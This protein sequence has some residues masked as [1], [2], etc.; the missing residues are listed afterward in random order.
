MVFVDMC[1]ILYAK[2]KSWFF[3]SNG[4][5][6]FVKKWLKRRRRARSSL[7]YHRAA[8]QKASNQ[9]GSISE[10]SD[11][12]AMQESSGL[13]S[14]KDSE[15]ESDVISNK[16]SPWAVISF[17]TLGALDEV[18]YFPTLLL[19]KMFTPLDLCLGTLLASCIVLLVVNL[20]LSQCKPILDFLDRIPLWVIVGGFA[21]V[22][23]VGVLVDVF[24]PDEQ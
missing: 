16:P 9:Y 3:L 8:T 13:A 14:E 2:L 15:D 1:Q 18:S 22:L 5:V 11:A 21:T 10:D 24:S 7:Q 17:T 12:E 4:G 19:G 6:L 20:F 23:T